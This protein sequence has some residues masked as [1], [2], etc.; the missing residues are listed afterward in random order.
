[1]LGGQGADG[2]RHKQKRIGYDAH[3]PTLTADCIEVRPSQEH[4]EENSHQGPERARHNNHALFQSNEFYRVRERPTADTN[5]DAGA[6]AGL[7]R[8][9]HREQAHVIRRLLPAGLYGAM[10]SFEIRGAR[11]DEG[12]AFLD[13]LNLVGR[14]TSL[15]DVHT[16]VFY[17]I[18]SSHRE[19]P[20]ALRD[21]M[22]IRENLLRLSTGIEDIQADLDQRLA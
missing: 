2:H 4:I 3:A 21:R 22:G 1:V 6:H 10:V 7:G 9:H 8:E 16:M 13:R 17:P 11:R 19:V 20:P 12:F 18:M 15:G 14:A 5:A